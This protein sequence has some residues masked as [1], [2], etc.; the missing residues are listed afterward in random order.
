MTTGFRPSRR[1]EGAFERLFWTD[2]ASRDNFRSR[3]FAMFSEEIVRA[4]G[5]ND[6][7]SYRD[8]GRPTL[9]RGSARFTLDFTLERKSDGN[10][11]V[12]EQ[13]A[14]LA[15]EGY[16]RLRLVSAEQV[17]THV[18]KPA[19]DWFLELARQPAS[20]EVKV[21][22]R[23]V[24]IDGAI[25][26]WGSTTPEGRVEAINRF[27]FADVLSLEEMLADLRT[28]RDQRW[29]SRVAELRDWTNGLFDELSEAAAPLAAGTVEPFG[30]EEEK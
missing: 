20:A 1:D 19:F 23:P 21:R 5:D 28:W 29:Q 18:G 25:L 15:W 13:K 4:W 11:Y 16:S 14:E 6:R 8:I 12:A 24:P 3:L 2:N 9:W 22:A 17:A 7:A 27:G 30:V 10:L 26:V